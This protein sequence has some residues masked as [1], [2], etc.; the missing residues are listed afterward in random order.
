[1]AAK[2]VV[3]KMTYYVLPINDIKEHE[4]ESTCSCN[5]KVEVL[6]NGDMLII[7]NSFDGREY[8]EILRE[9]TKN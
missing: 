5:P 2:H 7:H 3:Y 8:V 9:T 6:P 1:M 4:E